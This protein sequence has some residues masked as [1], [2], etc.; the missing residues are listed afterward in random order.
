MDDLPNEKTLKHGLS[1]YIDR[2]RKKAIDILAKDGYS[3]RQIAERL[4]RGETAV[5]T[6]LQ[7]KT[8]NR[9]ARLAGR[10][11]NLTVRMER[12]VTRIA[13]QGQMTARAILQ[14]LDVD[15]HV[16]SVQR[17]LQRDEELVFLPMKVRPHL[18]DAH[19]KLRLLQAREHD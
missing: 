1:C 13:K 10:R 6:Y 9:G 7:N 12:V 2:R 11:R 15:V 8:E 3:L 17:V 19:K 5:G 4:N 14:E 18:T 16:R